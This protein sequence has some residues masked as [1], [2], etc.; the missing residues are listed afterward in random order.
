MSGKDNLGEVKIG[1]AADAHQGLSH[2]WLTSAFTVSTGMMSKDGSKPPLPEPGQK[3]GKRGNEG[4][5]DHNGDA[6]MIEQLTQ[7]QRWKKKM[8]QND[9]TLSGLQPHDSNFDTRTEDGVRPAEPP[10][11]WKGGGPDGSV[12]KKQS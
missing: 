4:R 1:E 12:A 2:W 9:D 11:T 8:T 5:L 10:A 6:T 7:C 3:K